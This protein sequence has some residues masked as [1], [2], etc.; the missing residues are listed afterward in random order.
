MGADAVGEASP[1]MAAGR[2]PTYRQYKQAQVTITGFLAVLFVLGHLVLDQTTSFG[3]RIFMPI[4]TVMLTSANEMVHGMW[5]TSKE[6]GLARRAAVSVAAGTFFFCFA[7]T[8][9]GVPIR[10]LLDTANLGFFF[11]TLVAMPG[12][13]LLTEDLGQWKRSYA[14]MKP[15]N[16]AE[17]VCSELFLCSIA[18][19]WLGAWVVPLDWNAS[20]QRWPIPCFLGAV[21]GNLAGSAWVVRWLGRAQHKQEEQDRRR[22]KYES[23][24]RQKKLKE[25]AED[26]P[27]CNESNW[28]M[29]M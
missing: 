9:F 20:W 14:T 29:F 22:R 6:G 19:S 1:A 16:T 11:S 2:P 27:V 12:A 17:R 13:C 3:N 28:W 26:A 25:G 18:G 4:L 10:S 15:Q 23:G 7:A 5:E 21:A 8:C 24:A